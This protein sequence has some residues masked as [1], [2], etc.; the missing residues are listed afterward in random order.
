MLKSVGSLRIPVSFMKGINIEKYDQ[1]VIDVM[2]I[3]VTHCIGGNSAIQITN[4]C[5]RTCLQNLGMGIY[6]NENS[7][8]ILK[9]KR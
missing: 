3:S 6:K 7:Q 8:G 1:C 5:H 9:R 4:Y 2:K